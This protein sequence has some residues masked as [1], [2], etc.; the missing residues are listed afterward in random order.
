MEDLENPVSGL[1]PKKVRLPWWLFHLSGLLF[2][3]SI[4]SIIILCSKFK[5]K[6]PEFVVSSMFVSS[7]KN[8]SEN[9][10][11]WNVSLS[12]KNPNLNT[13]IS[14][15]QAQ[16]W[17]FY[18]EKFIS[19]AHI[20]PFYQRPGDQEITVHANHGMETDAIEEDF[21]EDRVLNFDLLLEASFRV[22]PQFFL[23]GKRFLI[24]ECKD[25]RIK[26]PLN[27][28]M[29][30]LL[31]SENRCMVRTYGSKSDAYKL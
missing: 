20:M 21:N 26:F 11:S 5:D 27:H 30:T 3:M 14:Y 24:V 19:T 23:E 22:N 1:S 7:F 6:K 16:V 2:F 18:K 12:M 9:E 8:Y 28:T 10:S 25:L 13:Y 15:D 29:G 4:F 17:L 31:S